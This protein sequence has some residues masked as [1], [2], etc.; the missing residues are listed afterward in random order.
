MTLLLQLS[1]LHIKAGRRPAYG[2]VDTAAMLERAVAHLAGLRPRPDAVLIT[3]D[4]VDHGTAQDYA[5]LRELLAPL[6]AQGAQMPTFL[7]PGNHDERAALRAAFPDHP[8]MAQGGEFVQYTAR[9][10]G[11]RLVALDTV[12]PGEGGGAVCGQRLAWLERE[13]SADATPTVVLMHHPP[14]ATGIAHMDLIGLQ[15]AEDFERVLAPHRHVERILCGHLHRTIQA[16]VGGTVASTCPSP[17]HQVALD[18]DPRGPD[19]FVMEPPGYQ[20]HW[21]DGRRLVTHTAVLGDYE[22]P[23]RFREGG[24]LID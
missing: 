24:S 15:G 19:C 4:L 17:A 13:L 21:W 12:V 18:L 10:G 22:G 7:I 2:I 1:D 8:W 16:R 3:G 11:L 5:L 20:L 23:Y 6:L 14:F 9:V